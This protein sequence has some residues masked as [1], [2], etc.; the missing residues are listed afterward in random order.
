MARHRTLRREGV[1]VSED[2][3]KIVYSGADMTG[4][5][6]RQSAQTPPM[7]ASGVLARRFCGDAS[8]NHM[9]VTPLRERSL[10]IIMAR[11]RT[12]RRATASASAKMPRTWAHSA[13]FLTKRNVG[14]SA[15]V[16][17]SSRAL[18]PPVLFR[19]CVVAKEITSVCQ[20][21]Q[22]LPGN[23]VDSDARSG[24]FS[25]SH[26]TQFWEVLKSVLEP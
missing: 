13:G 7:S 4:S 3:A 19:I 26:S 6:E 18:L 10:P 5:S 21:R 22:S 23:V 16:F 8:E 11:Y 12:L 14:A 17:A 9:S 15:T 2:A 25:V 1:G 24:R 20:H